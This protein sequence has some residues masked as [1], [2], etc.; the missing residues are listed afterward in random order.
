MYG[1][2]ARKTRNGCTQKRGRRSIATPHLCVR[3]TTVVHLREVPLYYYQGGIYGVV[4]RR[5]EVH[6]HYVLSVTIPIG[7]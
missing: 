2:T 4:H 5:E 1:G 6:I 7:T 3:T